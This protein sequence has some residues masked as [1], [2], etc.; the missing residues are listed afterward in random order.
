MEVIYGAFTIVFIK[1]QPLEIPEPR[2]FIN[3]INDKIYGC[4]V[5]VCQRAGEFL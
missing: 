2:A 4:V 1:Y 5:I 3:R